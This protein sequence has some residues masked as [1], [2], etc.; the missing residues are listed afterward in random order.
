MAKPKL[1]REDC[2][3]IR[4][5]Y[6]DR[7]RKNPISNMAYL[8]KV[9][10]ATINRV[11]ENRY[12]PLEDYEEKRKRMTD[13]VETIDLTPAGM[14]TPEGIQRVNAT[15]NEYDEATRSLA[16]AAASFIAEHQI[17]LIE[18]ISEEKNDDLRENWKQLRTLLTAY[19]DK[20]DA[21]LRAVAGAPEH[22]TTPTT[23]K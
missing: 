8:F 20:Q 13:K 9:N 21:F 18:M 1:T 7:T 12:T 23:G 16:A 11:I 10:T 3:D 5:M 17:A 6:Y 14:Q 22:N 4:R 15:Q 19:R 2:A